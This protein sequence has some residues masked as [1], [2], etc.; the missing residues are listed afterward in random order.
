LAVLHEKG[1][2]MSTWSI[3]ANDCVGGEVLLGVCKWRGN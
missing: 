3:F 2:A 1:E